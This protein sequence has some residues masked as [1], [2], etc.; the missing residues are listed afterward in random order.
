MDFASSSLV[1]VVVLV[2]RNLREIRLCDCLVYIVNV[3]V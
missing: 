2:L 1:Y 3:Q